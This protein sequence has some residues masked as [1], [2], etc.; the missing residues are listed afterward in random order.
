MVPIAEGRDFPDWLTMGIEKIDKYG[1]YVK[2]GEWYFDEDCS[3]DIDNGETWLGEHS[4]T[5]MTLKEILDWSGW[6]KY[7]E[8]GGVVDLEHYKET[9][10]VGKDP[11]HWSGG[12]WGGDYITL[13]EDEV[14]DIGFDLVS[15]KYPG[16]NIYV[17]AK[18]KSSETL[19]EMF[20]W[21][22]EEINRL[23]NLH[24]AEDTYLIIGFDS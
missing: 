10:A 7:L 19:R 12:I 9:I 24:G 8:Q 13:T 2:E 11:E 5:H 22:L 1:D 16:K 23:A 3:P 15:V 17:S 21:F 4:Q 14:E 6:D 20:D 18:W